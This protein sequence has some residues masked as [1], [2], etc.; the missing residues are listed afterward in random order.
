MGAAVTPVDS[1]FSDSLLTSRGALWYHLGMRHEDHITQ[2]DTTPDTPPRVTDQIA[3][4]VDAYNR[5]ETLREI[6]D[7]NPEGVTRQTIRNRLGDRVQVRSRGPRPGKATQDRRNIYMPRSVHAALKSRGQIQK[8]FYRS[9][10]KALA[11]GLA[12]RDFDERVSPVKPRISEEIWQRLWEIGQEQR[13]AIGAGATAVGLA[14]AWLDL[15][16]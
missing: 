4:I 12:P 5:G 9:M 14:M 3:A 6:A 8:V 16:A 11:A 2:P 10:M 1:A 7:A 13:P 15:S